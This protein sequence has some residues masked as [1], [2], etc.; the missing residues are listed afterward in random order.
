M[1]SGASLRGTWRSSHP[2]FT[3]RFASRFTGAKQGSIAQIRQNF[4]RDRKPVSFTFTTFGES[5]STPY[6]TGNAAFAFRGVR[7]HAQ[8]YVALAPEGGRWV[9]TLINIY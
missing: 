9:I 1:C 4:L 8:I 7:Q 3:A 2:I 6:A 5:E